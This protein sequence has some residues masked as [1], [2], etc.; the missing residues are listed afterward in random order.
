[1]TYNIPVYSSSGN[2][3]ADLNFENADE[4]LA[5]AELIRQITLII[6][7]R[8]LSNNEVA[9][10]LNIQVF[11]VEDLLKGKL[12]N[13]STDTLLKFLT[14]LGKDIEIVVK[15]TSSEFGKVTVTNLDSSRLVS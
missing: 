2:V 13:F 4:M 9:K 11:M 5:K 14:T 6:Q 7:Q 15:D 12:L 3:F 10:L 8:K 1:M